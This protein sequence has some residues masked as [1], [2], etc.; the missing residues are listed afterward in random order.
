MNL[1]LDHNVFIE[2][3]RNEEL[4]I[5]ILDV[6]RRKSVQILYS[7]AHIEEIYKVVSEPKSEHKEEQRVLLNVVD[8]MTNSTE[9]LPSLGGLVVVCEK[10]P[11]VYKRVKTNDTT[12]VVANDSL[13]RF[14]AD[15]ETYKR[16][17]E[18]DKNNQNISNILPSDIWH[19]PTVKRCIDYFNSISG[20]FVKSQNESLRMLLAMCIARGLDLRLPSDFCIRFGSYEN[21]LKHSYVELETTIELL[22]R[23]LNLCG[24]NAEK[25]EKTAISSTHDTTHCIYATA[26]DCMITMDKKFSRKCTAVYNSLGV[27]TQV[28]YCRD[29]EEL[30]RAIEEL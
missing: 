25:K 3:A 2:S 11:D 28:K 5:F 27:K 14:F 30:K 9:I 16:L 13:V 23:I 24:Y 18:Q 8:D 7:P 6:C 4:K 19:Y 12:E 29:A 15:T 10:T 22:L 17:L 20:E 26:S 1:Y 21:R